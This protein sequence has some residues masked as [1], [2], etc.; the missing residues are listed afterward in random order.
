M[1]PTEKL[2]VIKNSEHLYFIEI[3]GIQMWSRTPHR[4]SADKNKA[5]VKLWLD[6]LIK[7]Q[8]F[9][10]LDGESIPEYNDFTKAYI[11]SYPFPIETKEEE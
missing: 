2:W 6:S 5:Y 9:H 11:A 1:K 3:A 8:E 7:L 4:T 10:N